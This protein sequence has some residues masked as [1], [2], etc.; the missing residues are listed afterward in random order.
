MTNP[1]F[2]LN[3]DVLEPIAK[4]FKDEGE[5]MVQLHSSTRQ[6]VQSIRKEWIGEAAEKF[7][8]E[9]ETDLLP[10]LQ[11]LAQALFCSQ[12]IAS[13]IMKI[14]QEADNESAAYFTN[15]SVGDDLN[16]G[17]SELLSSNL[18][19]DDVGEALKATTPAPEDPGSVKPE[20]DK[21]A[22]DSQQQDSGQSEKNSKGGQSQPEATPT[23]GGGGGS[24]TPNQGLEGDLKNMG[25]GI[26]DQAPPWTTTTGETPRA[27]M[28]DHIYS[29]GVSTP[30]GGTS[31]PA[32]PASGSDTT[33]QSLAT[34]G[35]SIA[36]G[37]AGI[38]ATAAAI[39][40]V[41]KEIKNREENQ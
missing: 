19:G 25:A 33:G 28:P 29:S 14:I 34:D 24:N 11:R 16:A 1:L 10:A 12:D 2:Q 26:F 31:Q 7:F 3:Y 39:G 17:M 4:S 32:V 36:A 23:G 27:N 40:K 30:P 5:D 41:I 37:A 6:R 15:D 35:G 18:G 13:E 9:M 21:Q 38:A 22:M 8:E 20:D